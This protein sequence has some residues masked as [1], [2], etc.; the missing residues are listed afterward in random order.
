SL[1]SANTPSLRALLILC[2]GG[3]RGAVTLAGVMSLPLLLDSGQPFPARDL[4]IFLASCVI[5]IS[6]LVASVGLPWL[7][8]GMPAPAA[9]YTSQRRI[10]QN[11]AH[12]AV[13]EC[14]DRELK[15]LEEMSSHEAERVR[16]DTIPRILS[17][18]G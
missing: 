10:A 6:L 9:P 17:A 8:R 15:G 4:A 5:I 3:V 2:V 7:V 16:E 11:A 1:Q 18:L 12:A 14:L 13:T